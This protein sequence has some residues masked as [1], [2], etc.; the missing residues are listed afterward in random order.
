MILLRNIA[1]GVCCGVAFLSLTACNSPQPSEENAEALAQKWFDA[2]QSQDEEFLSKSYCVGGEDEPDYK[3]L[4]NELD[5]SQLTVSAETD[6]A[7][8]YN[9]QLSGS[10]NGEVLIFIGEN[11]YKDWAE[12]T[13]GDETGQVSQLG[14]CL[15]IPIS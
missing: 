2:L 5:L 15:V 14:W 6:A 12:R 4:A 10:V 8:K 3:V 1:F 7:G 13:W 9:V 11:A